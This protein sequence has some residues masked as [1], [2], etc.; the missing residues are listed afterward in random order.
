MAQP[1]LGAH[2]LDQL[3]HCQS[4]NKYYE[5]NDTIL[6]LMKLITSRGDEH[7]SIGQQVQ[8]CTVTGALRNR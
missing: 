1:V 5:Q 2:H 8:N 6:S 3:I 4:F 7:K